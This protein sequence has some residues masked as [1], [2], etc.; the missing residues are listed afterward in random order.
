[1]HHAMTGR[2]RS[3][4]FY[5]YI[6]VLACFVF[7]GIGIGTYVAFGVFFKPLLAEFGWSRAAISGASSTAFLLSGLLGILAGNL[8]DRFGPRIIMAVTG[9]FYGSGYVLLSQLHSVWQLYLF[10]GLVLGI[11]LS[12]ID[13][14]AL[15]TTA[16]WFVRRRGIMTGLVK[17]GTGAGQI[18]VPLLAS[19][20]IADCGWRHASVY[21]GIIS[22]VFIIGSG[23]LLR[24]DPGQ[25]G[26]APEGGTGPVSGQAGASEGGLSLV[27]ALGNGQFWLICT[28]NFLVVSCLMTIMIH[29]VPHAS[30]LGLD[31]MESA[32]VLSTIGGASMGGRLLTGI[33]IDRIGSKKSIILCFLLLI[34]SFL[35]LQVAGGNWMLYLFAVVYGVS[36][37]G[38]FTLIS[39]TVAELFGMASHG[40]LIGIVVCSGTLGGAIGP[41]VAGRIFDVAHSYQQVF[42]M[43]AAVVVAASLLSLFLKPAVRKT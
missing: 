28:I 26:Q 7:Q 31:P 21:L 18:F 16:R 11:G 19:L 12:S 27:E 43:L 34:A 41:V 42:L 38:F 30:D 9:V 4:L 35:W 24:R 2:K 6:I 25:M 14:I 10:F 1:M 29:I 36:H 15:T 33:G 40:V 20:L 37:G 39:P 23:Q 17:T 5:G 22:L 8:N 3:N 32:G 13:V